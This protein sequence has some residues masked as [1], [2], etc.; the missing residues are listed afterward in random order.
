LPT[1]ESFEF[2]VEK[3]KLE[4]IR[5]VVSHNCGEVLSETPMD[6][7]IRLRVIKI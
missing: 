4:K 3:D 7:D 5:K 2:I 1:G 6:D